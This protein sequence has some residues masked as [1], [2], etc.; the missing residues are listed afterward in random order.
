MILFDWNLLFLLQQAVTQQTLTIWFF[1]VV[2]ISVVSMT[3]SVDDYG[4]QIPAGMF[5]L[6]NSQPQTS[7]VYINY[8]QRFVIFSRELFYIHLQI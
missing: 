2:E 5:L 4:C 6:S 8:Q 3:A 7:Q 1:K